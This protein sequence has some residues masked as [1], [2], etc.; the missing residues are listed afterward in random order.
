LLGDRSFT[1]ADGGT[2]LDVELF[3]VELFDV[4]LFDVELFDVELFDVELFDV[5]LTRRTDTVV[6]HR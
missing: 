4:E 2:S 1:L 6:T 5:E 3:D